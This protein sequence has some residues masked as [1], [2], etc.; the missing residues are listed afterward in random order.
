[1]FVSKGKRH[2]P[3]FTSISEPKSSLKHI[4]LPIVL[5]TEDDEYIAECPL[6]YVSSHGHDR[7]EALK[8]IDEALTLYLENNEIEPSELEYDR[9]EVLEKSKKLFSEFSEPEDELPH[10]D[11]TEIEI[12]YL[13]V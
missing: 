12:F 8:R 5:Y 13:D 7:K 9:D 11:Y 1:M 3:N 2:L 4:K 10:F 6:F